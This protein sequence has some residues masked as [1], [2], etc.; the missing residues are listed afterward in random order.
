MSQICGTLKNSMIYVEV[1]ITGQI[2]RPFLAR[3]SV[4]H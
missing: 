1:V 3:N 4:L 2:N